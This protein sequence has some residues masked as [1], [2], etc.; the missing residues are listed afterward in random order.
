[1]CVDLLIRRDDIRTSDDTSGLLIFPATFQIDLWCLLN[2][3]NREPIE[4][5]LILF[6]N[7]DGIM[8]QG[9]FYGILYVVNCT[10]GLCNPFIRPIRFELK[11]SA[12]CSLLMA[13]LIINFILSL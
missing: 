12:M 1:M 3:S 8:F 13:S 11:H 5:R 6:D 9:G 7:G 2:I 4:L 10:H